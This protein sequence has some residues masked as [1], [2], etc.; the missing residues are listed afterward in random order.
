[1]ASPSNLSP[2]LKGDDHQIES[3]PNEKCHNSLT[4][5]TDEPKIEDVEGI[6][7]TV[8]SYT[9]EEAKRILRKVDYRLVPLLAVLYLLA[10]IDRGNIANAKIAGM[11][12]DLNLHG[13][14]YNIAL[15]LFF[16]PYGLFEVPS[17]IVL[18][19]LRPSVWI[20]IMMFSWGTVMTLMGV[21]SNYKGL[22]ATRW[23]L[24]VTE[25]GFFPAATYLLTIWYK[26]YEVQQRMAVFYA[27][28]SLSGAFSGLL[29][30]A[31]EKMNG[32]GNYAGWRW[33]FIIEG[34]LP[35]VL[36]A[37]VWKILPDSP[38]QA[39]FLTKAERE[40]IVNR[41]ALET[42]S[43][44]GKVTN[45]DKI[46]LHHIV[47]A[48]KEWKIWGAIILF[49][50]NTIGV[51]GFT[52][53]VPTVIADLGYTAAHAQLLTIPIYVVAMIVTLVFAF[54]SDRYQQRTPFIIAGYVIAV[55]GFTSQLAIPHPEYPGL[56]Y[57]M[58]FLVAAGLYAPFIS[59]VCLIGNNLAPSS[60]RAV[61]M[62][63]LISIG[64][65]GGIA[66]SN[67]Y[68]ENEKPKYPTGFGVSLAMAVIAIITAFVLRVAYRRVNRQRDLLLEQ[69][70]EEAIRARY[71]DQELLDMGDMSPFFRYT[72]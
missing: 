50:A 19:M 48:F 32:V 3:P 14:Q 53:T 49:W 42:G 20:S 51:Y 12:K 17:N 56:T 25:S 66:G 38:E 1:M 71:T 7:R 31:I 57:G 28:A 61:G 22:L 39:R 34:L 6:R 47:A 23:F 16:V 55:L 37:V 26:R 18:K 69:E 41:L 4:T 13:S 46:Q 21:I 67:I 33:I 65:W 9:P 2:E 62:A 30:F 64:N 58:L 40:F 24:G 15:T 45:S 8:E 72:L 54:V 60:K 35:V 11:E 52:A 44:H 29:A 63:L 70:G 43:G 27:A 5:V 10:F 59:I 68:R 36:A